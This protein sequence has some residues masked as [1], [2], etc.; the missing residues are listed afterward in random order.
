MYIFLSQASL[1]IPLS[2]W[3]YEH[4]HYYE[5]V[6]GLFFEKLDPGIMKKLEKA[7]QILPNSGIW[8][9]PIRLI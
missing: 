4:L 9:S 3:R 6:T 1:Q 8:F 2:Y 7:N 5:P